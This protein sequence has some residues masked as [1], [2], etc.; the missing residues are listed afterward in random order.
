MT[1]LLPLVEAILPIRG[2]VGAPVF[3]PK[4]LMGGRGYDSEPH[5]MKLKEHGITPL[6]ARRNTAHGSGLGVFRYVVEQTIA[7]SHQ[8]R[9]LRTRFDERDDIHEAFTAIGEAMIC[10]RRFHRFKGYF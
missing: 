5:R 6:L 3:K 2:K 9:H 8:L 7:L 10:W 4:V 1:Q